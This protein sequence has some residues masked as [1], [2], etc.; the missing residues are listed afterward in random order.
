MVP[1]LIG[2][3]ILVGTIGLLDLVLT[4]GVIRR[5]REHTALLSGPRGGLTPF[6]ELGQEIG[7][8]STSTVNGQPLDRDELS[9]ETLVG[10]F[11]P[12]CTPCKERIGGFVEY[13]RSVPG[14]PARVLAA[15]IG[16][17]DEAADMVSLL[18]PVANVVLERRG[19]PLAEAFQVRAYPTVVKVAAGGDGRV[20]VVDNEVALDAP[21]LLTA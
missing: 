7:E 4:V 20:V 3:V 6:T 17:G 18:R 2:A 1:V 21:A 14:G 16:D 19:G 13:A 11:T 8:F 5:L 10:F 12:Q 9:S 15:V